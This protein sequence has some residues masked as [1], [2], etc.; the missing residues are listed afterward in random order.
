MGIYLCIYIHI[1]VHMYDHIF[2]HTYIHM[3]LC[4][5]MHIYI[6]TY[7]YVYTYIYIYIFIYIYT[8][9]LSLSNYLS[10]CLY[11]IHSYIFHLWVSVSITH[12]CR[13]LSRLLTRWPVH[14]LLLVSM[15]CSVLQFIAVSS[16][17]AHAVC[18]C[19]CRVHAYVR[20]Q[21]A[22]VRALSHQSSTMTEGGNM[23]AWVCKLFLNKSQDN[24]GYGVA[25]ISRLLKIIGLFCRISSL[26]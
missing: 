23:C 8:S 4:I 19:T 9:H 10:A 17:C 21:C 2:I 25:S 13:F 12:P 20:M 18:T 14:S 6:Y 24:R 3:Y 5:Y 11:I 1:C 7:M 16:S 15:R 26:L 22:R